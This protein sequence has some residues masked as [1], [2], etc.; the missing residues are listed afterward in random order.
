MKKV[1][2]RVRKEEQDSLF[3]DSNYFP[4]VER[5]AGL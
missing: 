1:T 4:L 3:P 2:V 5:E